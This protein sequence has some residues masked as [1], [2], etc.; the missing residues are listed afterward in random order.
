MDRKALIEDIKSKY[1]KLQFNEEKH[2]YTVDGVIYPSTSS[3]IKPFK[4][5]FDQEKWSKRVAI[6]EGKTQQEIKNRWKNISKESCDF[7]TAVHNFGEDYAQAIVD[8]KK[9]KLVPLNKHEEA[10][11]K[12]WS[13]LP[14]YIV[15]LILELKM[16]SDVFK[17]AGTGDIILLDTRDNTLIL[18]DYK[19]NKD[20]FKQYNNQ[21]MR[22]GFHFLD[23]NPL[24]GYELQLS[25]YQMLLEER[26]YKV[27]NRVVVWLKKTG[28]YQLFFTGNHTQKLRTYLTN[29]QQ[30]ESW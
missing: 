4:N 21:K 28:D 30:D 10:I 13:E 9:P 29:K 6:S 25:F 24:G 14:E 3:L 15:P 19:T 12:F 8:G 17:Y 22:L 16:Y 1:S 2:I 23:D 26:G 18:G 27:S 20:L 11:V 7:G 5:P